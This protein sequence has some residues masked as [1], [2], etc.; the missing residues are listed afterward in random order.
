MPAWKRI[1]RKVNVVCVLFVLFMGSFPGE[2]NVFPVW[3]CFYVW[4][5]ACPPEGPHDFPL[6]KPLKARW[7]NP[8]PFFMQCRGCWISHP[9]LADD[10][11]QGSQR[12]A[13]GGV[14]PSL[15]KD[16]AGHWTNVWASKD[17]LPMCRQVRRSA[18]VHPT[19]QLPHY[20]GLCRAA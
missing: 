17:M 19:G 7:C 2:G 8:Q 1:T 14:Q 10:A 9:A 20:C 15:Q 12:W 11:I 13:R 6:Q 18:A 5:Q 16:T 4:C 3:F